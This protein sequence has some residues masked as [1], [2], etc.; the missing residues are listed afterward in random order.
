MSDRRAAFIFQLILLSCK[1]YRV[2][3]YIASCHQSEK[4]I[5]HCIKNKIDRP[6]IFEI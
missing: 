2:V 4:S 5:E 6:G 1:L 3:S